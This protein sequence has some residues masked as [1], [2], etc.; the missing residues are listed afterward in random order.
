[1]IILHGAM[2]SHNFL[3]GQLVNSSI[4]YKVTRAYKVSKVKCR[5]HVFVNHFDSY[6]SRILKG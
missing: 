5:V 3:F 6:C 2:C 4:V 1:M